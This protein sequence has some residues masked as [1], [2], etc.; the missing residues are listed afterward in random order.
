[1]TGKVNFLSLLRILTANYIDAF[2]TKTSREIYQI[3][4]EGLTN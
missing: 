4:R 1:M 3:P 2:H